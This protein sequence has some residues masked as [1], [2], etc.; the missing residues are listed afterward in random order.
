MGVK[1]IKTDISEDNWVKK[2]RFSPAPKGENFEKA[3]VDD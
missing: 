2:F 3:K 1:T